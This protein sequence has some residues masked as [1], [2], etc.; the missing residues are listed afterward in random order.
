[1]NGIIT[2]KKGSAKPTTTRQEKHIFGYFFFNELACQAKKNEKLRGSRKNLTKNTMVRHRP[3]AS[4]FRLGKSLARATFNLQWNCKSLSA[5]ERM[6]NVKYENKNMILYQQQNAEWQQTRRRSKAIQ[7]VIS[8][9]KHV[10]MACTGGNSCY[11]R[12]TTAKS[13]TL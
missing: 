1:M 12:H 8:R 3:A 2:H 5:G 13:C 6:Y 4:R 10:H 11:A 7:S 9:L